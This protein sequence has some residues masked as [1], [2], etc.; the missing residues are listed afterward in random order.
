MVIYCALINFTP[1]SNEKLIIEQRKASSIPLPR[2]RQLRRSES[3][4]ISKYSKSNRKSKSKQIK[5]KKNI[6]NLNYFNNDF[7]NLK[8]T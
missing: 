2:I 7:S 8:K 4:S 5:E 6:E 1:E 3:I